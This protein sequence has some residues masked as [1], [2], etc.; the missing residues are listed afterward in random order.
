MD[1]IT[2]HIKLQG[3]LACC[4]QHEMDHDRGVLIVDHVSSDELLTIDGRA[5]FMAE[6]ENSDGLHDRRMQRAYSRAVG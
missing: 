6:T 2:K 4:V 3:E 5:L 1:G